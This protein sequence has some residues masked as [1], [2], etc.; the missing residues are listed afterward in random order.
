MKE[1]SE[2]ISNNLIKQ[3]APDKQKSFNR[4]ASI[5][6]SW[7][8]R[9][10]LKRE[11]ISDN[12]MGLR[13]P[14]IGGVFSILSHWTHSNSLATV[15]M[16]T[17]TGKTE[18]MLSLLVVNQMPQV[19]VIVPTV[20]LRTQLAK[21]FNE[22]GLLE[23]IG[24]L[25]GSFKYP[26]VG[27]IQSTFK[28]KSEAQKFFKKCNVIV[29]TAS[30]LSRMTSLI[31]NELELSCSHIFIDE[32]HHSEA[33]T[34]HKFRE[35][36]ID[37]KIVQFTATP[38]RNDKKK[39]EGKI[40]YSFP[41]SKAQEEGYFKQINFVPIYEYAVGQRDISLAK[42]AIEILRE[43]KK[44]YPH[45]LL[46]RVQTKARAEE[47]Y[48]IY[49]QEKDLRVV[50]VHSGLSAKERREALAI[51]EKREVD[52][53]VC[54]DM[55]GEGFDLPQLKIAAFHDIRK[56]LPIT[57]QF[58]GRFTRTQYDL[59]L[60]NAA[61]VVNLADID[62]NDELDEL[63]SRDPNWNELLPA[64]SENRT[65]EEIDLYNFMH[66][67]TGT[68]EF[69]VS[70]Q[71]MK[72]ALS[73]VIFQ[74]HT[75]GWFPSNYQKALGDIDSYELVRHSLNSDEK[76]LV[77]II[78]KRVASD[79]VDN[80]E[81]TDLRWSYFIVFWES[82]KNLLF[83][84]SS[85][86]SSVHKELAQSIIGENAEIINGENGGK[87]FRVLSG[88][89][90]FKLQ[91]LG[92]T[93]VLGKLVRF[94]MRVGSDI[95]PALSRQQLNQTKKAMIFGSGYELGNEV[96]IGC[97]Y[98]GRIWSRRKNDIRTF[99]KWCKR[100]GDKVTDKNIDANEV[101]KDCLVAK[102]INERPTHYPFYVDWGKDIYLSSEIRFTFLTTSKS[103]EL[104]NLDLVL[105]SPSESDDLLI[106]LEFQGELITTL[107]LELFEKNEGYNDFKFVRTAG[108]EVRVK[109]GTKIKSLEKY[110]Y[111]DTPAIWFANGDFLEGNNYIELKSIGQA[112][113]A[114]NIS[115]MQW[116]G[117]DIS[118]ESQGVDPKKKNSIQY[119]FIQELLKSDYDIIYDDDGSGEI[120]DV[121][122][123]RHSPKLITVELYHLKY[124]KGGRIGRDIG[125]LYEVCGQA[126]KSVNW[127]FKKSKELLEHLLRRETKKYL[128]KECSRLSLG[129]ITDL[130]HIIDLVHNRVPME[131][132]IYIVQP[133]LSKSNVS[134]EQLTLLGVTETY[135]KERA[136]IDLNVIG[137]A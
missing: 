82:E 117:V 24:V 94:V 88:I 98:K 92:L 135:L 85:D 62:V 90:M 64:L 4:P 59:K 1:L 41:L 127:K 37:K 100:L 119:Y 91:N 116:T 12:E 106:G 7:K 32:A 79:W 128:G 39:I 45:I 84:H 93:E 87:V 22:L 2:K 124:A 125:N 53:I 71:S 72:P 81:V 34:W 13:S 83:I 58:V 8:N 43:D 47:V 66:G 28:S 26:V 49:S 136:L 33:K 122:T 42:K 36:F 11:N 76:V 6:E 80:A 86:N 35:R 44:I 130:T 97:S 14:Q 120:A 48:K 102:A 15:V 133:G 73:T 38:F 27:T 5:V 104:Y 31:M 69:P 23:K 19:L 109:Y 134:A 10:V 54:V 60:G 20:P 137:S 40:V 112:F 132:E 110:F 131:F 61:V 89:K 108:Q 113:K 25:K 105:V 21:K 101:L 77:I 74:N 30:I 46:A 57:L 50:Q 55:L 78:A 115:P 75:S 63:Y 99:T 129:S 9:V 51:I 95:E 96:S 3:F 18:T 68:Q 17:G 107:K 67:F 65:Q 118:S 114:Q 111:E 126:Q 16:P 52:V 29:A 70:I 121:L 123:I 56:S 103:Y